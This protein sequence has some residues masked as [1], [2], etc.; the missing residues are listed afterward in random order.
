M[1]TILITGANRGIGLEFIRQY[2]AGAVDV[3]ACCR[4]PANA[5]ELK[6]LSQRDSN[7]RIMKLDVSDP[8]SVATLK[9]DLVRLPLDIV[10][11]NAGISGLLERPKGLID[12]DGWLKVFAVNSIAPV[13]VSI[14][15]RDNLLAGREKKLVTITSLLG[16]IANHSG[17]AF[18]YH[19]SK[20]AVNSLMHGLAKDWARDGISVGLFHP[21]WVQ[22]DMGGASAPVK[23][24]ESVKGLRAQISALNAENSGSFRDYTGKVLPW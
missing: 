17:G 7:V 21:G 1:T 3:I 19:A 15:L 4:E 10:I 5:A 2:A 22:T 12:F 11:N 6:A 16:S 8:Q 18:P 14:A 9:K 20:A 23:R 13:M 24:T